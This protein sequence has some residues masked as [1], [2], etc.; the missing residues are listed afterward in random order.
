M[1][2]ILIFWVG[3]FFVGDVRRYNFFVFEQVALPLNLFSF[4]SYMIQHLVDDKAVDT[5]LLIRKFERH[6]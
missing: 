6:V 1:V 3:T 4:R 2:K 5:L